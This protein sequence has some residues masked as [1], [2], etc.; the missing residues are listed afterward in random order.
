MPIELSVPVWFLEAPRFR[1]PGG[2]W[3]LADLEGR[4]QLLVAPRGG[5]W[6]R[7][8]DGTATPLEGG[9][10]FW[11]GRQA[12]ESSATVLADPVPERSAVRADLWPSTLE[13]DWEAEEVEVGQAGRMEIQ[14]VGC[15][16]IEGAATAATLQAWSGGLRT[17][18]RV[19]ADLAAHPTPFLGSLRLEGSDV[20]GAILTVRRAKGWRW[21]ETDRLDPCDEAS[22]QAHAWEGRNE[23]AVFELE[24]RFE[25]SQPAVR[26]LHRGSLNG[27]SFTVRLE[28]SAAHVRLRRMH[29]RFHGVQRARVLVEGM[30]V[31]VWRTFREDRSD[32]WAEDEFPLPPAAAAG[33]SEVRVTIDPM[34][35]TALWDASEYR[36]MCLLA[37]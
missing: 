13:A 23:T 34:P 5:V 1:E 4:G 29:D 25:A 11:L 3:V 18:L 19:P 2:L 9:P 37:P 36:A 32:R 24:S 28:P 35:G 6:L 17:A 12:F 27:V 20:G 21:L 15:W 30:F 26:A 7:V 33:R 16:Q 22:R 10:G 31:G 14:G 8:D